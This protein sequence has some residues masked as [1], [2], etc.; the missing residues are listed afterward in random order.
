MLL[1]GGSLD[2][3]DHGCGELV[4]FDLIDVGLLAFDVHVL[5]DV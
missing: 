5:G 1:G 4:L 3:A 2:E